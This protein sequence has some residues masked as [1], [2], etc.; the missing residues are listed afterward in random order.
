VEEADD[1]TYLEVTWEEMLHE[2]NGPLLERLG[3]HGVVRVSEGLLND[4]VLLASECTHESNAA[5]CS[6]PRPTPSLR[7]RLVSSEARE[8]PMSGEYR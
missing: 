7:Y 5:Y 4:Y 3:K 2:R 8:W 6:M 1:W